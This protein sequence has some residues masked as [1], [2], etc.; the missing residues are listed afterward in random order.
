MSLPRGSIDKLQLRRVLWGTEYFTLAFGSIVGVGWMV[1]LEDWY[2]RGG[3]VGAMLG[4]LLGGLALGPVAYVYGRL[5]ERMPEAGSE[6][7]Y[8]A[9]VFPRAVS[10]ASGWA[11]TLTY[12]MV[13]P[14]EAVAMGR[15]A[16]Y[17]FPD[18][19]RFE[20]YQVAGESVYLPHLL[21]A[22]GTIAGITF[23][24]YRGVHHS[25]VFQN[26]TTFGL[27]AIFFVFAPLGLSR[28][29]PANLSPPFAHEG[30]KLAGIVSTLQV[31]RI[32]PYYLLGFET[33]PKCAE[34]AAEGFST[35][36]FL[37]IM[38]LALGAATI[39]YV[40][41][42]GV[43]AMLQPWQSLITVPFATAVAFENA[44]GWPWL[45][46]LMMVGVVLSLLKVTN[47]NFLAATRLLY[48][49]GGRHLLGRQLGRVHPEFQTPAIAILLVGLLGSL[50][51][52]FGR[53][54]LIPITE[55]GS[56]TC[57]IGWLATCLA[58]CCG[59]G[60]K[61]TWLDWVLGSLGALVA[62]LFIGI[63][64]TGFGNYEWLALGGWA[65]LG[66]VLW[67]IQWRR[68]SF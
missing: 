59:A 13:V 62:M 65:A 23:M 60:G 27:L 10:F 54:I 52:L 29:N 1:V 30:L 3:S 18:L 55:V 15:I 5:A 64:A 7:A 25:S 26:L 33:I 41:I 50:I 34:E 22:I 14:W 32:V 4:F 21:I 48:A 16:A 39:F 42:A 53:A 37:P 40:T 19:N 31:L 12:I 24:N 2:R 61:L 17:S 28:G 11:L 57:A 6:V 58:F 66:I 63:V 46:Q 47:G 35:R 8:T 43:V 51:T 9:A 44:F 67:F 56:F 68:A 36:R 38:F 45:V 20:L 49:M